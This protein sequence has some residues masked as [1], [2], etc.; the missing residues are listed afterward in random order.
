MLKYNF[1]GQNKSRLTEK[2]SKGRK[3]L[4]TA[5]G[6]G[7]KPGGLSIHACGKPFWA[8][9]MPII[10]FACEFLVLTDEDIS[11]SDDFQR[12]AGRRI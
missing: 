1:L 11:I 3:A 10:T 2:I 6:L 8:M 5:S 4:N 9:V 7:L 12:Y